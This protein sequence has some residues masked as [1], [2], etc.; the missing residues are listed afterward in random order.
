MLSGVPSY[1]E[2]KQTNIEG[3]T[4]KFEKTSPTQK[5]TN[6]TKETKQNNHNY[7]KKKQKTHIIEKKTNT[8]TKI[9]KKTNFFLPLLTMKIQFFFT[10]FGSSG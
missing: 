5:K 9:T 2:S 6:T 3:K 8:T 10:S 4:P 1:F 7:R